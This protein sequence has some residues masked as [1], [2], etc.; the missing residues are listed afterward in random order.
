MRFIEPAGANCRVYALNRSWWSELQT[1]ITLRAAVSLPGLAPIEIIPVDSGAIVV[2]EAL[3]H[4]AR[5]FQRPPTPASDML[6][7]LENALESCRFLAQILAPLHAAGYVWLNFDPTQIDVVGDGWQL[8]GLDLVLPAF[9]TYPTTLRPPPRWAAPEIAPYLAEKIAE[10]ADVFHLG[11]FAYYRLAGLLPEGFPGEGLEAFG[12]ELPPLRIYRPALPPGIAPLIHRATNIDFRKR[13][14]T[15]SE[16]LSLFEAAIEATKL[17]HNSTAPVH[18]ATGAITREG[19]MHEIA[20]LGNQ[21]AFGLLSASPDTLIAM[22]ADGVTLCTVGSGDRASRMAVDTLCTHLPPRVLNAKT[23]RELVDAIEDTCLLAAGNI[24]A[25]AVTGL[26][27]DSV[28]LMQTMS[29]TLVLTVI[30]GNELTAASVGDSRLYLIRDGHCEQLNVDGDV[31]CVE[32]ARGMSPEQIPELGA[33]AYA[34][35]TCL[36][37][38]ELSSG[39]QIVPCRAR[40]SPDFS[41]WRL[42]PGDLLLLATDGLV[43]EQIF[44]SESDVSAICTQFADESAQQLAERLCEAARLRHREPTPWEPDGFGDD[45]T[46]IVIRVS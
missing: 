17:R 42:L 28:D 10:T 13:P 5:P 44:L 9:G 2:A 23:T 41:R 20:K 39:G 32:L 37:I 34:L 25:E 45:I 26:D 12:Y 3:P 43:E 27:P 16:F 19:R 7:L 36:G 15:I 46:C 29:T 31:R 4:A 30:R 33:D 38:G 21:D 1:Q 11:L 8:P 18:F 6:Q 24:L 35:Y 22:V 40:C 14:R